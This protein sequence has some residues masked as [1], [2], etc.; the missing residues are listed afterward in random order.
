VGGGRRL[1][2]I[3]SS[4]ALALVAVVAA[5]AATHPENYRFARTKIDDAA[6]AKIVLKKA[7]LP[8]SPVVNGG[9]SKPDETPETA[10]DVCNGKL[11]VEHDLVVTGDAHSSFVDQ[12]SVLE[13]ESQARLFKTAAMATKDFTRDLGTATKACLTQTLAKDNPPEKLISFRALGSVKGFTSKSWLVEFSVPSSANA[14]HVALALTD[15]VK[16]RTKT[17][18]AT[19][20]AEFQKDAPDIALRIQATALSAI[21]SRMR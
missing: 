21:V 20:L 3:G 4:V 10:R 18:L 2:A 5:V 7:D 1:A 16:G 14:P 15:V 13:I 17:Q 12:S 9:P 8:S 6:A 19:G 11:Q